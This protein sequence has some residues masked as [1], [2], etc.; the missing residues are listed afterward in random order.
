MTTPD[1][2]AEPAPRATLRATDADEVH[3]LL[4]EDRH[5]LRGL[6]W[7]DIAER[8]YASEA[9]VKEAIGMLVE[10]DRVKRALTTRRM[11]HPRTGADAL[12]R[13]WKALPR[14]TEDEITRAM[15]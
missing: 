3:A 1:L 8:L 12:F 4:M 15:L 14:P 13:I 9:S 5:R 11:P 7:P 2:F 10:S 6:P